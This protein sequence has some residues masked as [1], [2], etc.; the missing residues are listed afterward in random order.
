M[1]PRAPLLHAATAALLVACASSMSPRETL[2]LTRGMIAAGERLS[3][4]GRSV[5]DKIVAIVFPVAAFVAMGF[6]HSI[7]NLFFLPY[8]WLLAPEQVL[9]LIHI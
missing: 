2:A 7:A 9:S 5:V 1:P 4:G 8:A 6:E 3:W